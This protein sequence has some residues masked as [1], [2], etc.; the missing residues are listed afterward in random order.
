MEIVLLHGQ[1]EG[2]QQCMPVVEVLGH[3]AELESVG[4][5]KSC[6]DAEEGLEKPM[7]SREVHKKT[8]WHQG[9]V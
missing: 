8:S 6:G 4:K 1:L 5:R 2:E 3:A 9:V 7:V